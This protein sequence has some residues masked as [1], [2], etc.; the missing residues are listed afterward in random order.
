MTRSELCLSVGRGVEHVLGCARSL[1]VGQ[2]GCQ[3]PCR[4]CRRSAGRLRR[5]LGARA[6]VQVRWW[7]GGSAGIPD[8]LGDK[9]A[10]TSGPACVVSGGHGLPCAAPS[11]S[12][13]PNATVRPSCYS[14]LCLTCLSMDH[15]GLFHLAASKTA[16]EKMESNAGPIICI[17]ESV[18]ETYCD[19]L[20]HRVTFVVSP[21]M[22]RKFQH[23]R[24]VRIHHPPRVLASH[25]P[26]MPTERKQR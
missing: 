13:S 12:S 6:D 25:R 8:L 5:S 24:R 15:F 10:R 7:I 1:S 4:P 3:R 21:E 11:L 14:F 23:H 18:K 17:P 19:W 20:A 16:I 22:L 26:A 9:Q 2:R